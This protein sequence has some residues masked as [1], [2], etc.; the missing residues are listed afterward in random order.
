MSFGAF[1]V[2]SGVLV[3]VDG[4]WGMEDSIGNNADGLGMNMRMG[5]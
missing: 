2:K 4:G 3:E 1:S 5:W